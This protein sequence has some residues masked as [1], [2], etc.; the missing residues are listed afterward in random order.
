MKG[1]GNEVGPRA[2][3][4]CEEVESTIVWQRIP[5][6]ANH[7]LKPKWKWWEHTPMVLLLD[8]ANSLFHF[9]YSFI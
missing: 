1:A 8:N 3:E 4:E 6:K 2:G 5:L 7:I 9:V